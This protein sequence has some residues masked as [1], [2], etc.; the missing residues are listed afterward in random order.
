MVT[1][2]GP[3]TAAALVSILMA[4]IL[5]FPLGSFFPVVRSADAT[6]ET[7]LRIGFVRP[8]DSLNP[9]VGQ[10]DAARI[11]YGLVYDSLFSVDDRMNPRPDL[12]LSAWIVP[13]VDPELQAT[14]EPYGSVWQ[15]NITHNATWTDGQPFTADDVVWNI[16]LNAWNFTT[17]WAYQPY[18]YFMKYAEK[19][20]NYTVRVH[21]YDRATGAAMPVA[22]GYMPSI[23]M[24]PKH[25]L[26]SLDPLYI[27]LNWS[28]IFRD[29]PVPIVGTGAFMA[30][31][32]IYSEWISGSRIT[33]VGNPDSHWERQYGKTVH[34][35]KIEMLFYDNATAESAA[36]KDGELDIGSL[37]SQAFQQLGQDIPGENLTDISMFEGPRMTQELVTIDIN[38]DAS[39]S[40]MSRLD[41]AVRRAMEMATDKGHVCEQ[42]WHDTATPGST[43]IPPSN[44]YWHYTLTDSEELPFDLALANQTLE[45]AGYRFVN[46]SAL[47]EATA[48]SLAVEENWTAEGT[49][50]T[51]GITVRDGL[52]EDSSVI[53]YLV[54]QWAKVGIGL[55]YSP[56]Y[57][58]RPTGWI[59]MF[60]LTLSHWV[61]DIDPEYQLFSQTKMAW[62]GWNSNYYYNPAYDRNYTMS[63][64]SMD[65]EQRKVYVDNCQR[66]NYEDVSCIVLAYPNQT[67]AWRTDTFSGW[68]NWSTDP[69]RSVDNHW[70][71]NPLYFDLIPVVSGSGLG[72]LVLI[73]AVVVAAVV[74][75]AALLA[76]WVRRKEAS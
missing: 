21:F 52:P 38:M 46:G 65:T 35:D 29:K 2:K 66:I 27:S 63:I 51:F 50:L 62:G 20:D 54:Q 5:A 61:S 39:G 6:P 33:L 42:I 10:T 43:L 25:L 45:N 4:V 26:S 24:L 47:R 9:F 64:R 31:S 58:M 40:G 13:T 17:L 59:S 55:D 69:G 53:N 32:S 19:I 37:S 76:L 75:S 41:P 8:V 14:H 72:T 74:A 12:A 28:G 49:P 16:N 57:V 7:V 60:D 11:F 22:Y 48:D 44:A 15:Y 68:G 67:Y 73:S 56:T 18:S 70:G 23:A 30:T 3:R 71:G 34:F 36:L 1:G